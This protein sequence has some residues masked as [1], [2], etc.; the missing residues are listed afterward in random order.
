MKY[1]KD[2]ANKYEQIQ[3]GGLNMSTNY[4]N[5]AVAVEK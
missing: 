4:L 1:I 3:K 2:V 5:A